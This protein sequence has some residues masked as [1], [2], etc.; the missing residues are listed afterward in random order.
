MSGQHYCLRKM[1]RI[2]SHIFLDMFQAI[3]T[4]NDVMLQ[5]L[6]KEL[7]GLTHTSEDCKI[8]TRFLETKGVSLFRYACMK[9]SHKCAKELIN[10]GLDVDL[11]VGSTNE[12]LLMVAAFHDSL[13]TAE[14]LFEMGADAN[15]TS[16]DGR[17][18]IHHICCF[19]RVQSVNFAKLILRNGFDIRNI[20]PNFFHGTF[21]SASSAP[22]SDTYKHLLTLLSAAGFKVDIPNTANVAIR[23]DLVAGGVVRDVPK[24]G[25]P[26]LI[27]LTRNAICEAVLEATNFPNMF[28]VD[29]AELHLPKTLQS[30]L[31]HDMTLW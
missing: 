23:D 30:F 1:S 24:N 17:N 31:L 28:C 13:K 29:L 26:N 18:L 20:H 22:F 16:D 6:L 7:N 10:A 9:N 5:E 21:I 12:S 11:T 14:V 8:A 4:D 19:P 25:P 27:H 2:E 15:A 3:S